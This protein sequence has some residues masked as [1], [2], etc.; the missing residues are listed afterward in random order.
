ME[1]INLSPVKGIVP[2]SYFECGGYWGPLHDDGD[3]FLRN[4]AGEKVGSIDYSAGSFCVTGLE[5]KT[6]N[7]E[8]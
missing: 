1:F 5:A 7:G 6:V 2:G 8:R 3:G 4:A